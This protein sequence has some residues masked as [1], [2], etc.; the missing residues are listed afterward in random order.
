MWHTHT[1]ITQPLPQ[2]SSLVTLVALLLFSGS[3][4]AQINATGCT[5]S[6]VYVWVRCHDISC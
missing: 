5:L 6:S 3:V 1:L 2:M 4:I